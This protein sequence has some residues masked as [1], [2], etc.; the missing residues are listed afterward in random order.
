MVTVTGTIIRRLTPGTNTLASDIYGFLISPLTLKV[1][2]L[3]ITPLFILS[4]LLIPFIYLYLKNMVERN[5]WITIAILGT[6]VIATFLAYSTSIT[7]LSN[8]VGVYPDV[9]YLCPTYIPLNLIGLLILRK[10]FSDKNEIKKIL[11]IFC[12]VLI[13]GI[14]LLTGLM[15]YYHSVLDFWEMFLYLNGITPVIIYILLGLSFIVISL[16]ILNITRVNYEIV[17]IALLMAALVIWQVSIMMIGN[18]YPKVFTGYPSLLPIMRELFEYLYS[19]G[20]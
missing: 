9:R 12:A 6:F 16:K 2:L 18:F 14:L 19:V 11:I 5:E 20:I 7:G 8:S 13:P 4:L 3:A 10:I 1:P 17:M 15:T